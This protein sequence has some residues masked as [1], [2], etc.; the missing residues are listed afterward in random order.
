LI[1]GNH[2]NYPGYQNLVKDQAIPVREVF[3]YTRSR[4]S[5]YHLK[6]GNLNDSIATSYQDL[7]AK[8]CGM[9]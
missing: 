6:Y 2:A 1:E 4:G 5:D 7:N 3:N 8:K 9:E